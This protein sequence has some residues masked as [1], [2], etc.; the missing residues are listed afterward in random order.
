MT[1]GEH[2]G[3]GGLSNPNVLKIGL[4]ELELFERGAFGSRAWIEVLVKHELAHHFDAKDGK[5][6]FYDVGQQFEED[7]Y[8]RTIDS[9]NDAADYVRGGDG[10][11]SGGGSSSGSGRQWA[12]DTALGQSKAAAEAEKKRLQAAGKWD[13]PKD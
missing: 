2:G 10:S 8:G 3:F 6:S 9:L 4:Q 1:Y 13:T 11:L 7:V 12:Q 5:E